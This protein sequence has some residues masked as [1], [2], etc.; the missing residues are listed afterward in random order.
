LPIRIKGR[1]VLFIYARRHIPRGEYLSIDYGV[2]GAQ[3]IAKKI[4]EGRMV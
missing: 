2:K 1:V 3:R 4:Q